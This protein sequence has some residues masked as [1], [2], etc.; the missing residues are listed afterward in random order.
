RLTQAM[1]NLVQNAVQ[2]TQEN[3]IIAIGSMI[4]KTSKKQQ[5]CLWVRDTGVGI[6]LADQH[7]IFQRF[8]RAE[9]SQSSSAGNGLGLSIVRAIA[10]SH[11]GS[12]ELYSQLG[13][14]A[15]FTLVLPIKISNH[16][17]IYQNYFETPYLR[18][19]TDRSLNDGWDCK[20]C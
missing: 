11:G 9:N 13:E 2:H 14:G 7:R 3:D 17:S 15:T 5:F 16:Q 8:E 12:V 4:E 6:P 1:I 19:E 10:E 20:P 18:T